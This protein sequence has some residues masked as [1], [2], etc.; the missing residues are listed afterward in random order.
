MAK[1]IRPFLVESLPFWPLGLPNWD[2]Q[3]LASGLSSSGGRFIAVWN[4]STE[5]VA[6]SIPL[7]QSSANESASI[8]FP[9][10][11]PEPSWDVGILRVELPPGP[12]ARLIVVR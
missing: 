6:A 1:T 12:S 7:S 2:D 10:G 5:A 11:L 9:S 4:L 3:L 8:L